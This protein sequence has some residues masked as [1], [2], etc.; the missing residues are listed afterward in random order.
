MEEALK[1]SSSTV[2]VTGAV[3]TI[4]GNSGFLGTVR[5]SGATSLEGTAHISTVQLRLLVTAGFLGTVTSVW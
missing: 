4:T 2:T 1:L 3:S 5:V